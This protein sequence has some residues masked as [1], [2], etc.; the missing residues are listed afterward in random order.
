MKIY[1]QSF[2]QT[3]NKIRIMN[4]RMHTVTALKWKIS[5]KNIFYKSNQ[6]WVNQETTFEYL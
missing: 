1:H 4:T 2:L 5:S 6:N 3:D